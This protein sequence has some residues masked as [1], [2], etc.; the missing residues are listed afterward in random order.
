MMMIWC[1]KTLL[2]WIGVHS[3]Q[4]IDCHRQLRKE[5]QYPNCYLP[6]LDPDLLLSD[7]HFLYAHNAATGYIRPELSKTGLSSSY[8]K[9]QVGSIYQQ[10][11]H[12]ARALDLRPLL[13][14]NGTVVFQ[15]DAI[16]IAVSLTQVVREIITW[17]SENP[18][19][20]VLGLPNHYLAVDDDMDVYTAVTSVLDD[21]GIP[22]L[23]CEQVYG[24]TIGEF[25]NS[26]ALE[27]GG[28]FG[29]ILSESGRSCAKENWD[30]SITCYSSGHRCTNGGNWD[31][32]LDYML[33]VA[34]NDANDDE[35]GPSSDLETYPLFENQGLWQVDGTSV[36]QGTARFSTLLRD[37][38]ISR[39][40]ERVVDLVYDQKLE[41]IS[42]LAVDN[43]AIHGN[44]LLSVLRSQCGQT[45]ADQ[46]GPELPKPRLQHYYIRWYYV[47][48]GAYVVWFAVSVVYFKRPRILY[49]AWARWKG[50]DKN[51]VLLGSET[52]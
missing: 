27:T 33:Q 32:V 24:W 13:L 43:V 19:E 35:L 50:G 1:L 42:L 23:T 12:G 22:Y 39:I 26:I 34:N 30:A 46:C 48:L 21:S 18:D 45:L 5:F 47:L 15:H 29:V 6:S 7:A 44:A 28:Y 10:L 51:S 4:H 16:R 37:N 41:S 36:V 31:L 40:N 52:G 3:F 25:Q 49:T 9:T 11:Q 20:I 8:S 38:K 2:L 14:N 17:C